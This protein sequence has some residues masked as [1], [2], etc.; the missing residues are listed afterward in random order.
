MPSEVRTGRHSTSRKNRGAKPFEGER[1]H[2]AGAIDLGLD[3]QRVITFCEQSVEL[4]SEWAAGWFD[5]ELDAVE[6]GECDVS[7]PEQG[8]P[9]GRCQDAI[10]GEQCR[11]HNL[12]VVRGGCKDSEVH[13]AGIEFEQK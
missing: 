1:G 12:W 7:I 5:N 13:G 8:M 11:G 10:F 6:V 4:F 2:E 9:C 3:L